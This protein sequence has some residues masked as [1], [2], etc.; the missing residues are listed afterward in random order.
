MERGA[1]APLSICPPV[2]GTAGKP[3][4]VGNFMYT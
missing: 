1:S 4:R 2:M 3:D